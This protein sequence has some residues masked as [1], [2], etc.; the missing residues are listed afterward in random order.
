LGSCSTSS[1]TGPPNGRRMPASKSRSTYRCRAWRDLRPAPK[2]VLVLPLRREV[3]R[4]RRRVGELQSTLSTLRRSAAGWKR[5][6]EAAPTVPHVSEEEAKAARLSPRLVQSLRRRLGLSQMALARLMGV[7][8]GRGPLGGGRIDADRPE[9]G[10]PGGFAEGEE[11]RGEGAAR[12]PGQGDRVTGLSL[13]KATAEKAPPKGG[14]SATWRVAAT[15]VSILPRSG[16]P[17]MCRSPSVS[18]RLDSALL[19]A[20]AASG[21]AKAT[22]KG[23]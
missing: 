7:C 4:L 9:P 20:S 2:W 11:A 14:A 13:S 15:L 21:A 5:L 19:C 1:V 22:R 8:A 6:M 17:R 16:Q 10:D 18:T 12:T 3:L 23:I